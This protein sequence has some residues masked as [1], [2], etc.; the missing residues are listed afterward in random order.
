V[1]IVLN[2]DGEVPRISITVLPNE[3]E[4]E[5]INIDIPPPPD[6]KADLFLRII[7]DE[8]ERIKTSS[9]KQFEQSENPQEISF[10]ATQNI[11]IA[12]KNCA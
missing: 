11:Q 8:Y 3:N 4:E 5:L 9:F 7:E 2:M 1:E 12:K 6:A 10:Y